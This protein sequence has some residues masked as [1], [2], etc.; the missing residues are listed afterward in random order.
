M[1]DNLLPTGLLEFRTAGTAE[2]SEQCPAHQD[3]DDQTKEDDPL[4]SCGCARLQ[5]LRP[6]VRYWPSECVRHVTLPSIGAFQWLTGCLP[7][8]AD[9]S[10]LRKEPL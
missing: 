2:E 8:S 1:V 6:F 3:P 9:T 5:L 4:S 7:L 10:T